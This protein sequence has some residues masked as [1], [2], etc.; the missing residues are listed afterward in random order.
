MDGFE[1][2][3]SFQI[4]L[5]ILGISILNFSG[6]KPITDDYQLTQLIPF[7]FL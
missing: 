3:I 5:I 2:Y 7:L 6:V 4:W 1:S